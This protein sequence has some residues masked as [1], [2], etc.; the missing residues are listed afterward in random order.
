VEPPPPPPEALRRRAKKKGS[1][2]EELDSNTIELEDDAREGDLV[3]D[4]ELDLPDQLGDGVLELPT[5]EAPPA[6]EGVPTVGVGGASAKASDDSPP[7]VD[8]DETLFFDDDGL[9]PLPSLDRPDDATRSARADATLAFGTGVDGGPTPPPAHLDLADRPAPILMDVTPHALGVELTGG[10][11]QTLIDRHAPIPAEAARV[12]STARDDQEDVA[13]RVCQGESEVFEEN[14]PLGVIELTGLPP[15]P[16]GTVRVQVTFELDA[17]G[18]LDV[19]AVDVTTGKEQSIRVNLLGGV[20]EDEL[21]AMTERH[22]E[23]VEAGG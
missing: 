12:F 6:I 19:K 11:S 17:S 22:D 15:G 16:R 13:I 9:P 23:L 3:G 21:A 8:V 18:T 10:Y 2:A 5:V 14:D 1:S 20:D 7:S 4:L